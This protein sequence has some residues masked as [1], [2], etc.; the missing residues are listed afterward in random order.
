MEVLQL[1]ARDVTDAGLEHLSDLKSLRE[2]SLS[3]THV[4]GCGL[5]HLS[6][7]DALEVLNLNA[8]KVTGRRFVISQGSRRFESS[9]S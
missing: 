3:G 9:I 5:V 2:L 7:L 4:T 6:R 1:A 8:T